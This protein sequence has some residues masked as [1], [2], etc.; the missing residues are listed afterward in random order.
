MQS[1]YDR[2]HE[3]LGVEPG[4]TRAQIRRAYRKAVKKYHPDLYEGQ[5]ESEA[6]RTFMQI[7][8]AYRMLYE[9]A[10]RRD[11]VQAASAGLGISPQELAER[12]R[13]AGQ[14]GSLFAPRLAL[15]RRTAR[16]VQAKLR[17]HR[18]IALAAAV[19]ALLMAVA[20]G[21]LVYTGVVRLGDK[22]STPPELTVE[23]PGGATMKL[24][25]IPAGTFLMA[26]PDGDE[27]GENALP[28]QATIDKPFYVAQTEVTQ[29]QWQAV[30]RTRPW[31]GRD[32]VKEGPHF[33]ATY[34]SRSEAM[35]F[36]RALTARL[37]R[38]AD[39]PTETQWEY[40][41]RA[42]STTKYCFG[43]DEAG[44]GEYAWY[45]DNAS[46]SSARHARSVAGKKPNA[47]GLHDLHGNVWEWC[48]PAES[49][50]GDPARAV[51]RG[52]SWTAASRY[53]R[54]ISRAPCSAS[55]SGYDIGFRVAVFLD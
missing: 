24:L 9:L 6:E 52:G 29:A 4:A 36:C 35:R 1:K 18:R 44:L 34:V 40:A 11:K 42:G 31:A 33:P 25:L 20:C 13:R 14:A 5:E 41:C 7:A 43:D 8:D 3:L 48:A 22:A 38:P 26:A 23:L 16:M 47:W 15:L 55:G 12:A 30:M 17:Q 46:E 2:Y 51:I 21:A 49:S 50:V 10:G 19:L 53:C 28:H 39:L 27:L 45:K 54:S 37:D 32:R